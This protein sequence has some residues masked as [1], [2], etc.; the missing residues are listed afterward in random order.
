MKY[1][2]I[3]SVPL[4]ER[5]SLNS[6]ID[7]LGKRLARATFG[8]DLFSAAI[9]STQ[10]G[11]LQIVY[12]KEALKEKPLDTRVNWELGKLLTLIDPVR[13]LEHFRIV[14]AH[15]DYDVTSPGQV[16]NS[17]FVT[18]RIIKNRT[19]NNDGEID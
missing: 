16:T 15:Q 6:A 8:Y 1:N 18:E 11:D 2:Q 3:V 5:R 10:S 9:K 17:I 7:I 19:K 12:L 4:A 13:A 14:Q